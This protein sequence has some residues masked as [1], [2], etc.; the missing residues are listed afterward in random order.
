VA[1]AIRP[2]FGIS[3]HLLR[4]WI[5]AIAHH[6][7]LEDLVWG[8]REDVQASIVDPGFQTKEYAEI[9]AES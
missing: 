3:S 1:H 5:Q 4:E 8:F 6:Y 7:T 2:R 9:S